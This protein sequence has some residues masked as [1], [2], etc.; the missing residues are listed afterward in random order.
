MVVGW[1]NSL[2]VVVII[3]KM[4]NDDGIR[5]VVEDAEQWSDIQ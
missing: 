5:G 2:A 1:F 3:G 4:A